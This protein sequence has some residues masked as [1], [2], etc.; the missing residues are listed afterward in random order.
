[1][2]KR[3]IIAHF[4]H[5]R[6]RDTAKQMMSHVQATESYVFGEIDEE[7]IPDLQRQGLIVQTLED[8]PASIFHGL[9]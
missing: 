5:E 4:M 1:M 6:E 7:R 3:R 9:S 2:P 8:Q